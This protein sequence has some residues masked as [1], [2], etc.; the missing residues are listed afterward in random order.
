MEKQRKEKMPTKPVKKT[1]AKTTKSTAKKVA[2]KPAAAKST[3]K[4]ATVKPVAKKTT[5]KPAAKKPTVKKVAAKKVAAKKVD[6]PELEQVAP[7]VETND[8]PCACGKN[9]EC[10]ADCKCARRG[11]KFG[12]FLL[13]LI[14]VLFVFALGFAAAQFCNRDGCGFRCPRADFDNGCLEVSSVKCPRLQNLLPTMDAD[15]D[16]CITRQEFAAARDAL[17]K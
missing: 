12:R 8:T 7:V 3:V 4:K 15:Q 1:T 6:A 16:G 17:R 5:V 14:I 13:K 10:G 2:T 11:S 9:C